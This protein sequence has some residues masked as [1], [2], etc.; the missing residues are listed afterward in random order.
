M[1]P[2]VFLLFFFVIAFQAGDGVAQETTG[3][4]DGYLTDEAGDSVPFATVS[5]SSPSLQGT[6]QTMST[7]TGYY[8]LFKLPPGEYSVTFSHVSYQE[9]TYTGIVVGLGRTTTLRDVQLKYKVYEVPE[10]VVAETKSLIDVTTTTIGANLT[11]Q[12]FEVLPIER[13]YQNIPALLPQANESFLGDEVNFAGATGLENKYFIDGID[14]TDPY[15]GITGTNLPY[16]FV[17][18]VEVKAGAY[19]AEYRS[20]LGGVVNVITQPGGNDFHGQLYGFYANNRFSGDPRFGAF[21][22]ATGDFSQYD[23]GL[24]LGGPIAKDKLWFFAAYNPNVEHED[25]EI[26]G[27][28]FYEDKNIRHIFSGKLT[29]K[30]TEKLNLDL[31]LFGDPGTREAVGVTFGNWGI[32]VALE[33]PDPYL[34][35]VETGGV[36]GSL[37]GRYF[38]SDR[39]LFEASLSVITRKAY[40][41][42]NTERGANELLL[43]DEETGIWSGG[44][45]DRIDDLSVQTTAGIEGTLIAGKHTLKS[46]IEYRDNRLNPSEVLRGLFRYN[47]SAFTDASFV[48]DETTVHN[49]IPSVFVQDSWQIIDRLRINAGIRWDGQYL[50]GSNGEVAQKI[51]DQY[52]PRIGL[53]FQPGRIGSQKLYASFGRFYQEISTLLS[54][55]H[56]NENFV[57]S[58]INYGQDPR[59]DPSNGDT[60]SFYVGIQPEVEGLEGQ[61]YDEFTL[62]YELQIDGNVM[63]GATGIHRNLRQGIE[64]G[65]GVDGALVYGNPGSGELSE[66]PNMTR[67]YS[68]LVLTLTRMGDEKLNFLA[69]YVLSKTIG[70]YTGL[71]NS[72][73]GYAFPNTNGAFDWTEN[74]I[75]GS[76][77]LPNDRTHV[78]KFYGSYRLGFRLTVGTS[79]TW[80]SG[81]PLSTYEGASTGPPWQNFAEERG[82]S[83]R[84]PTIWDLNLRF[85][86]DIFPPGRSWQPRLLLDVF[87]LGSQREA[88]NFDQIQYF[89]E[90][91]APPNTNPNPTYGMATKYQPPTTLRLGLEVGF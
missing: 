91:G 28:G 87:H 10:V 38:V 50:V 84:T 56:H 62:G 33:N 27:L 18:E 74:L 6:R 32:P 53:V 57:Q 40:Y 24:S 68:A 73:F 88:V 36:S 70:N 14:V 51:Q 4:L 77:L 44:Y 49:R 41:Q 60:T 82:S 29:W 90:M 16:N 31:T 21:E 13:N 9:V 81:T 7:S 30:A 65:W 42:P 89:G 15:R 66:F 43:I 17:K 55:M 46:G 69:S 71:F 85:A 11:R 12:D 2:L 75:N 83:G 76:G 79:F 45:P 22:P 8:G 48:W 80:Q 72:D 19:E 23:L 25:V 26:P 86:Y 47:D 78:F 37:I 63:I 59:I 58:F 20:S 34:A 35:D 54:A 64:N 39:L 52:Q 5:V 67:E 61:H 1:R 3:N